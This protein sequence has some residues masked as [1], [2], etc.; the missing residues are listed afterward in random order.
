MCAVDT[1][2]DSPFKRTVLLLRALP[3]AVDQC[4]TKPGYRSEILGVV[5]LIVA[6]LTLSKGL[7]VLQ[8]VRKDADFQ[9]MMSQLALSCLHFQLITRADVDVLTSVPTSASLIPRMYH[10]VVSIDSD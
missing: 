10:E 7:V 4:K 6:D 1:T 2:A 9:Q 3:S 5:E 8:A